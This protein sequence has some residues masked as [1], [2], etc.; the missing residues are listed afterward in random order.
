[1]YKQHIHSSVQL[2][3]PQLRLV[4]STKFTLNFFKENKNENCSCL[5]MLSYFAR[6]FD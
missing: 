3:A 6:P 1:M 2:S 5:E 4:F